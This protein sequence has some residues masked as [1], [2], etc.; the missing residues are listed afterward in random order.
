MQILKEVTLKLQM[1]AIDIVYAYKTVKSVVSMLNSLRH[2]STAEFRK[3]FSD[4]TKLGKQLNG[5]GYELCKLRIT[6]RQMHYS[7]P[8]SNPEDYYRITLYDEFLS[9]IIC[10]LQTRFMENPAHEIALGL[11]YLLPSEAVNPD[12]DN[13][14]LVELVKA[15]QMYKDDLPHPLMM[16]TEYNLWRVKWKSNADA[17]PPRKLVDAYKACSF[18]QFSNLHTLLQISLTLP[19]TSCKSQQ[20][21]SQLKLVKTACRSTMTGTRPTGLALMK[22]NHNFCNKLLTPTKMQELVD[23]FIQLHPRRMTLSFLLS[24]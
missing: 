24:D 18:L 15:V 22:I 1:Q 20:S 14:Y 16:E 5:E 3:V 23:S 12:E 10:E 9:H 21:F 7:N 11:L 8:L 2:N 13:S 19:I 17:N 6:G 4:A